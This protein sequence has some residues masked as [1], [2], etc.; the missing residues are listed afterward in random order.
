MNLRVERQTF[1][2]FSTA[3]DLFI[4]GEHFC[5]TL[6]PK[7]EPPKP[8]CIPE[9]TYS[10]VKRF[11]PKHGRDVPHVENVPGFEEIEIHWGNFPQ[12]TDGCLLVGRTKGTDF[13]GASKLA[14]SDLWEKLVP[15]WAEG[16]EINITYT[17]RAVM[18]YHIETRDGFTIPRDH[19]AAYLLDED[20]DSLEKA[21][22]A[23]NSFGL[24]DTL[25]AKEGGIEDTP[26][27]SVMG[28]K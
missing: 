3:G 13:V 11:S 24:A 12:N 10:L 23:I 26:I 17:T 4:D 27:D 2:S 18:K 25:I 16:E 14:F 5:Y 1:T 7:Q 22:A 20:F 21:Q 19:D 28:T 9:G 15:I 8:Y 6:E